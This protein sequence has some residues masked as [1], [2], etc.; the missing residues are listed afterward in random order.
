MNCKACGEPI[1]SYLLRQDSFSCPN[2]GRTY[3]RSG[4][5]PAQSS[6][7][8]KKAEKRSRASVEKS[9]SG[10]PKWL[11]PTIAAVLVLALLA[12]GVWMITRNLGG[13][14][15]S[16]SGTVKPGK[17]ASKKSMTATIEIPEQKD[18]N[19]MVAMESSQAGVTCSVKNKTTSSFDIVVYNMYSKDRNP[20]VSWV[21]IPCNTAN[22][23]EAEG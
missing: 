2:C 20:T 12:G 8:P 9:G 5:K 7:A 6:A 13:G 15:Y 18:T 1:P 17:T 4:S 11:L 19:Y 22:A 10:M 23:I 3:R 16:V 14:R 21:L